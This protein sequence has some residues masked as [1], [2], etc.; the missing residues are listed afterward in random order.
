MQLNQ[1]VFIITGG[2]SGL[3]AATAKQFCKAGANVLIADI[4]I[5]S[6]MTLAKS[7]GS[8]AFFCKTD[9][10]NENEAKN[11]VNLALSHFGSMQGLIN[12]AGIAPGEKIIGK[13]GIHQLDTFIRTIQ[14]NLVGS[15]NMLRLVADAICQQPHHD[16]HEKGVIINTASIAAYEGQIGQA[17]YAASKGGIIG[18][19]LPTARELARHGIRVMT[20]APGLFFTP[21]LKNI[22]SEVLVALNQATIFPKRLGASEEFA[23]LAQQ[24][25][26]NEMLN[27]SVIR[28]DGAVRLTAN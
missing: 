2:A 27:G 21:M 9:I 26:E 18:M 11:A 4:N 7:I 12:C 24:I 14:I 15:F 20:I 25:V 13:K 8:Q 5:D 10:T 3:G 17:A 6:G 19:T 23:Q 22:N 16:N 28:L 1:A